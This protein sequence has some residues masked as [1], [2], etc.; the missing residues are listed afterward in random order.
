MLLRFGGA[1]GVEL[2][3]GVACT[4][5]AACNDQVEEQVAIVRVDHFRVLLAATAAGSGSVVMRIAAEGDAVG[6]A[7]VD[8]RFLSIVIDDE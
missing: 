4:G 2:P 1:D 8:G 5:G 7:F 6:L 3:E